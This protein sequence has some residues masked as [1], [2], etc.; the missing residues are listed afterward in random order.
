MVSLVMRPLISLPRMAPFTARRQN[1]A[2]PTPT[3]TQTEAVKFSERLFRAPSTS[4]HVRHL[5]HTIARREEEARA[6]LYEPKG[7]IDG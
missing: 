1:M 5:R 4:R 2:K 6:G 3:L 7:R